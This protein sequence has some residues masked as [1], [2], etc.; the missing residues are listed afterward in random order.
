M[1]GESLRRQFRRHLHRICIPG[2]HLGR[3]VNCVIK[4]PKQVLG[5][6]C[7]AFPS[8]YA[9]GQ[10]HHGLQVLYSIMNNDPRW[11]C[12]R[13]F[14][15]WLDFEALLVEQRLPLYSLETFTPLCEFDVVG[16]SLHYKD[17]NA[18]LLTMLHL[19]R[20]PLASEE[21][22]WHDPLMIAVGP[23]AQKPE[24]MASFVDLFVIGDGEESLPWVTEQ[25][26]RLKHSRAISRIEA[27]AR[28][29]SQISWGYAPA[30]YKPSY[31]GDGTLACVAST[32]SFT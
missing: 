29:V 25:W 32:S 3:E 7:L 18:T 9:I 19:S 6:V 27:I 20:I 13:A 21:R 28:L 26:M 31:N 2:Q 8:T 10:S 12:E 30:Y 5:R 24:V 22:G 15:P 1:R 16:F 14:T 11:A 4:D 17:L 23:G